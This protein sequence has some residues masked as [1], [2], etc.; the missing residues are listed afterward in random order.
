V[1][2]AQPE[3]AAKAEVEGPIPDALVEACRNG[4]CVVWAGSGLGA[5]G[6]LPTW[7]QFLPEMAEWGAAKNHLTPDAVRAA[8][9]EIAEGKAGVAA[10][11]I[12]VALE[13]RGSLHAYLCQR[14]RVYSELP[15]AH[16]LLRELDFP[17]LVTTSFDNLLD[18]AFPHSGGR[19]Y[20]A[21]TCSELQR[22]AARHEFLLLKLFGN[23]DEPETIRLGPAE[24]E[25]AIRDNPAVS[26][27]MQELFETRVFLFIGAS[28]EGL[29]RDLAALSPPA[30]AGR[31]HF[32]LVPT[33]TLGWEAAAERL[34]QRYAI[35]TLPYTASTPLHTEVVDFLTKLRGLI[36]EKSYSQ[37]SFE[38]AE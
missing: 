3:E 23:L 18:R 5:Q 27:L 12:A 19:I 15:A 33:N 21:E 1:D 32:A 31:K 37:E 10:D 20:T 34:T 11:R 28:L 35:A 24:C 26:E 17:A 8:S 2:L 14:F 38:T 30:Q 36:H 6:G 29:E 16:Q 7:T 13:D 22:A 4:D 9:A 25:R